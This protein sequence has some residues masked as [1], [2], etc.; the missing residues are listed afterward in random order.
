N[1][2]IK[3]GVTFKYPSDIEIGDNCVIGE[4]CYLVGKGGLKIGNDVLIGSGTKIATSEHIFENVSCPIREQGL[5]FFPITIENN[6]WL[7]FNVII[8]AG[9]KISEGSI[10]GANSLIN[11]PFHEKN[12]I[13]IGSP[14]K[15][16]KE[17]N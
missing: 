7:G 3:D 1:V 15:I 5:R 8:L 9:S 6:I 2:Q 11:K 10:V 13:L 14:A 12:V 17:R 16:Y 4:F